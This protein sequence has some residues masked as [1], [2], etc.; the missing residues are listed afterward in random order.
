[1]EHSS[2]GKSFFGTYRK[3]VVVAPVPKLRGTFTY[4]GKTR[5]AQFL[6]AEGFRKCAASGFTFSAHFLFLG[7]FDALVT[8]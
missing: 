8:I 6:F 7:S 1:M 3:H 4:L 2:Q 5:G